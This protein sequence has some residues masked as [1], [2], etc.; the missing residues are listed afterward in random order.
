MDNNIA[1][2][3]RSLATEYRTK[4]NFFDLAADLHETGYQSD[5]AA[6]TQG[7]AAGL[8][9]AVETVATP[10]RQRIAELEALIPHDLEEG[11]NGV[12]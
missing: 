3:L 1:L 6:I 9:V 7:I 2:Q 10:L 11:A 8:Q 12:G 4:A 5:Q